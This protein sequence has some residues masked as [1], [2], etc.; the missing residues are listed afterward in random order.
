M[1]EKKWTCRDCGWIEREGDPKP[2]AVRRGFQISLEGECPDCKNEDLSY[3]Q[4]APVDPSRQEFWLDVIIEMRPD[5]SR[6]VAEAILDRATEIQGGK[7]YRVVDVELP[8]YPG[9]PEDD[10]VYEGVFT[11]YFGE[12]RHG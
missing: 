8:P 4:L 3:S 9:G 10:G 1:S 7:D 2:A 11:L 12:G 6:E 5:I